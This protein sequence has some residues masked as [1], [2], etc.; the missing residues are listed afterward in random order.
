MP[1]TEHEIPQPY[2]KLALMLPKGNQHPMPAKEIANRLGVDRRTAH[3]YI[4]N[5]SVKHGIPVIASREGNNA[6]YYIPTSDEE[7]RTGLLPLMSQVRSMQARIEAV[8]EANL[9][10]IEQIRIEAINDQRD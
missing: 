3:E 4:H 1:H 9:N 6:G 2:L 7:R 10:L 8:E 5:L